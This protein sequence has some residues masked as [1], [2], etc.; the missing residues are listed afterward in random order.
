MAQQV[1]DDPQ[2]G[3]FRQSVAVLRELHGQSN[4]PIALLSVLGLASGVLE[5]LALTL[6]IRA[7]VGIGSDQPDTLIV[8][9]VS[10][11][12]D[13][14]TLLIAAG[15]CIVVTGGIHLLLARG[16]A[17]LALT[18]MTHARRR[19][20]DGFTNADWDRQSS[21]REGSLQEAT[22][23]LAFQASTAATYVVAGTSSLTILC[24]LIVSAVVVAPAVSL[25]VIAVLVPVVVVLQPLLRA[26]RRRSGESVEQRS[27][28]AEAVAVTTTLARELRTFGV[29]HRRAGHLYELIDRAS[30]SAL[31]TRTTNL[32]ASYLFKDL[33]LL[34]VILIVAVLNVLVDLRASATTAAVFLIIRALGYAQ[35]AYTVV[36]N[37]AEASGSVLQLMQ[38][39]EE[40]EAAAESD[41][42]RAVESIG[43]IVFDR[44]DFAYSDDRSAL[45]DVSFSLQ[46]GEALGLVGPS[47]SGKTTIAELLL[48]M[49]RPS[50]GTVTVDGVSLR[51]IKRSDWAR[52]VAFVPQDPRLSEASIADNIRFLRPGI[53]TEAVEQAARDAHLHDAIV[54]LPQGYDTMLGPRSSGLSGGQRQRLAI[55][56]ALA[57]K[58][59]VLVL[60][61]PTSAL[62]S[63]SEALFRETLAGLAGSVTLV[64]IAHRPTTLE[65][66][67]SI[68]TIRDGRIVR[69]LSTDPVESTER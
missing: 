53:E 8:L 62:D 56:R 13:A 58:P 51:D 41:G 4:R 14:T 46:P 27:A 34:A 68:V 7:V 15:G 11:G 18:V 65:V 43:P 52:H 37:S 32:L 12:D 33:A 10:V 24:A 69:I 38:R 9:G 6:F 23:A 19:L 59:S 54:A 40:L 28:L 1:I 63:A 16:A 21:E 44:V 29:G 60:D 47:G 31:R 30:H 48:G 49:R 67:D 3:G 35:L 45:H 5:A 55:A 2:R 39:I 25:V 36:Q 20:I 26:T 22:S 64:V 57:G 17:Q 66:C 50:A 61:E 42:Y